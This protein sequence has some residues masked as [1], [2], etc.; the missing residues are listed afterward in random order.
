MNQ[1]AVFFQLAVVL[2][3]LGATGCC[4]MFDACG[5][6]IRAPQPFVGTVPSPVQDFD[7]ADA[8]TRFIDF[9]DTFS[10]DGS[11][12]VGTDASAAPPLNPAAFP[13]VAGQVFFGNATG[14]VRAVRVRRLRETVQFDCDATLPVPHLAFRESHF[15]AASVLLLGP[16]RVLGQAGSRPCEV[17]LVDGTGVPKQIVAYR[18]SE[19]PSQTG[20]SALTGTEGPSA[21]SGR[22]LRIVAEEGSATWADHPLWNPAP[23]GV[24]PVAQ[25]GCV[26]GGDAADLVFEGIPAGTHTLLDVISSPDGC[27]KLELLGDLGSGSHYLCLPGLPLPFAVGDEL[28]VAPIASGHNV[29][30]LQG[31]EIIGPKAHLR[32]GRGADLVYFGAGEGVVAESTGCAAQHVSGD[33]YAK[34]LAVTLTLAGKAAMPFGPGQT[35]DLGGGATLSLVHAERWLVWEG[36]APAS[37]GGSDGSGPLR[38]ESVWI[39]TQEAP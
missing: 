28:F 8:Q 25:P 16:G 5:P 24:D 4:E 12:L 3:G 13:G 20:A 39:Q 32:M 14:Q 1:R 10:V 38:V 2:A 6:T 22:L 35:V 15:G 37:G 11:P 18:T 21:F 27:H 23:T 29:L 17:L 26:P 36:E 19:Y 30:P 33:A 34:A 7:A 31:I 9:N